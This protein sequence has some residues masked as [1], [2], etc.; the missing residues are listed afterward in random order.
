MAGNIIS[1]LISSFDVFSVRPSMTSGKNSSYRT[2]CGGFLGLIVFIIMITYL[3][4]LFMNPWDSN[5]VTSARNL[6]TPHRGLQTID[7]AYDVRVAK[8]EESYSE[9]EEDE[10][11]YP[12]YEGF[13]IAYRRGYNGIYD[14]LVMTTHVQHLIDGEQ[15]DIVE[16][17]HCS[18]FSY[19]T[20]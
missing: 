18:K 20:T 5:K 16:T 15:I 3:A 14:P 11:Y 4:I 1:Q 10:Y 7:V 6:S 8:S 13:N 2:A 19:L 9:A 17:R 12:F